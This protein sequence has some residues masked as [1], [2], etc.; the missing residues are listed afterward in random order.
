MSI[1]DKILDAIELLANNSVKK[2]GYDKTIQAQI[3]S[4]EDATIGKYRCRYQDA[5]FYAYANNLDTRLINGSY[6]YILVPENDMSKEKTILG[7]TKKLGINYISQTDGEQFYDIIGNNCII[8]DNNQKFYL[9]TN[10]KNYIY[11]LYDVN[12][13]PLQNDIQIE[14][15]QAIEQYI[16]QSSSLLVAATFK[17]S[18]QAKKQYNGHYGIAYN[19]KFK[20]NSN[21]TEI[22]K[23]YIIDENQMTG[24]PYRLIY[25]TRQ[26]SIF[27]INGANF[28]RI[29]SI[30]IFN[31]GFPQAFQETTDEKLYSGDIEI[32]LLELYGVIKKAENEISGISISFYT[33]QGTIFTNNNNLNKLSI[34]AQVKIKGNLV[35]STQNIPFYWGR[36]NI[37]VFTDNQ[38][39]NQYLGRGWEC[40]NQKNIIQEADIEQG[41]DAIVEWVPAKDTYILEKSNA[42]AAYTKLKVAIIYDNTVITK[43][44]TIQN[45]TTVPKITIESNEGIQFYHDMGNPT[46]ICKINGEQRQEYTYFWAYQDNNGITQELLETETEEELEGQKVYKNKIQN[47][48][49]NNITSFG[50]FKCSVIDN[51]NN[52][53]GT[54]SITLTNSLENEG[55]YSIV[56]NN[57]AV[58]YQY[59]ENGIAPDNKSLTVRQK[60]QAL[61]FTIYDNLGKP[62]DSNIIA[63]DSNCSIRWEFPITDTLLTKSG[64]QQS[65]GVDSTGNYEYYDNIPNFMYGIASR[66]NINAKRNQIKLTVNYKGTSLSAETQFVFAKQGEPGTNGTQYLVKLVPNTNMENAPLYPMVTHIGEKYILNYGLMAGENEK[67]LEVNNSY[68][69][70]KAQL[71][72]NGELVWDSNAIGTS[73]FY[74]TWEILANNYGNNNKDISCFEINKSTGQIK[75]NVEGPWDDI[76]SARAN[77]IKCTIKYQNKL[78]Y[79]TIPIITAWASDEKYRINLKDQTGWRYAVYTSDGVS[80]KYDTS[81]P[82]EIIVKQNNEDISDTDLE[83]NFNQVGKESATESVELIDIDN[84]KTIK[85][86]CKAAPVMQYNGLCVTAALV[87][88]VKENSNLIC[89]INIPIHFLLN[90]YGF[91]YINE[92][93]GNKI[94]IDNNGGFILTPQVIAGKKENDNTFT[95]VFMGSVKN[96]T[97]FN[98]GL[99]GYSEGQRT[100][101]LNSEDGSASFGKEGSG[102]IIIDPKEDNAS[103]YSGN[104]KETDGKQ[105]LSINLTDGSING[106]SSP[107]HIDSSGDAY[108]GSIYGKIKSDATLIGEGITISGTSDQS[109]TQQGLTTIDP[110][111]ITAIQDSQEQPVENALDNYFAKQASF[112]NLQAT[113]ANISQKLTALNAE[114]TNKLKALKAEIEDLIALKAEIEDL[115]ILTSFKFGENNAKWGTVVSEINVDP[116]TG[117]ISYDTVQAIIIDNSSQQN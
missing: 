95:G 85:N 18:I 43:E 3:L 53:L 70:L 8:T 17:T 78:Y 33:P 14:D 90:K 60:I 112:Q 9:N 24:N 102:Q 32:S 11:S 91:S 42:V 1:N 50:T 61:S 29:E 41:I 35:S 81:F 84:S 110:K 104:Y 106:K 68:K 71:W 6:V 59:N 54:A 79:G 107:W 67:E 66:Y 87:C 52:Y 64:N 25:N 36:E 47:V 44:I 74:A 40:L 23:S 26:F 75:C 96:N 63:N 2:A 16:K 4:C 45:L 109:S 12:K 92:W 57:G 65:S 56:L 34:T 48:Q 37:K 113:T 76:S 100:F 72:Y 82:F 116:D 111:K 88:D 115:E 49:I 83:Y 77:I 20:D 10:N 51:N 39:Y 21:D 5:V 19:L 69:F 58:A 46:L 101:F 38:Y 94:E 93:D 27:N 55:T 28:V 80:P 98:T 62:I 99:Q 22:I 105:G 108:F 73:S 13:H 31:K 114:I 117:E 97:K 7:T 89:N 86:K 30:N 15:I 103:I